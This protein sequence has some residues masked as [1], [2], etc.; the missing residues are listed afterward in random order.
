MSRMINFGNGL[1]NKYNGSASSNLKSNAEKDRIAKDHEALREAS[2]GKRAKREA[3]QQAR[4]ERNIAPDKAVE[5]L[6]NDPLNDH[7][8]KKVIANAKG[9]TNAIAREFG[10]AQPNNPEALKHDRLHCMTCDR[11]LDQ[12]NAGKSSDS[13]FEDED[14][15]L[16][17]CWCF[18]RMGDSDIK[19]T[20][21]SGQSASKEI[22]LKVYNPIESSK[23]EIDSLIESK[24]IQL[25]G[26]LKRWEQ[27]VALVGKVKHDYLYEGDRLENSQMYNAK[28]RYNACT[29]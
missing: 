20:M 19:S 28:T 18:G 9:K 26:K 27:D 8:V 25:R 2:R 14:V 21:Y 7:S 13:I 24:M 22:R 5:I 15:R 11:K 12:P 16:M 10:L 29:W 4:M 6:E 23:E 1:Q 17:C 3:R